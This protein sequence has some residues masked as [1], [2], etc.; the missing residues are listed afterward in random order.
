M[1]YLLLSPL[2]WGLLLALALCLA[3]RRLGRRLR[4]AGLAMSAL[5]LVLCTPLGANVLVR[6]A[7]SGNGAAENCLQVEASSPIVVLSGGFLR[8]PGGIDDYAALNPESWRRLYAA[9]RLWQREGGELV[10]AGGGPYAIAESEML[11]SLARGWGVPDNAL[12]TETESATTWENAF[13]L[14]DHGS[15]RIRLVTSALHMP[16]A[17][18]AFG[19]AGFDPCAHPSGSDYQ[20]PGGWGYFVP[21]SSALVKSE[22]A[23]HELAGTL[24]YRWRARRVGPS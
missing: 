23:L 5:P 8:S 20:P 24:A 16:R 15:S 1:G 21:Q 3:W 10:I 7:E 2:T 4:L 9:V 14:R 12:R 11:A 18:V 19:A 13:A 22:R 6:L 17:R